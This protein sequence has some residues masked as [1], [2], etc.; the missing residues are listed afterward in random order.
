M[1]SFWDLDIGPNEDD[2]RFKGGDLLGIRG[3]ISAYVETRFVGLGIQNSGWIV[4]IIGHPDQLVL[5]AEGI[6]EL[7]RARGG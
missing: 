1:R 6:D 3:I 7:G 4:A 5:H 2:V